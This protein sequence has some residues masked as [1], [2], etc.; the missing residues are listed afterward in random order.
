MQY[1]KSIRNKI[2]FLQHFVDDFDIIVLTE[3]HLD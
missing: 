2:D 3:T 1:Q